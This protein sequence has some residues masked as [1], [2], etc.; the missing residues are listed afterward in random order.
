MKIPT[1]F[2]SSKWTI[3]TDGLAHWVAR[4]HRMTIGNTTCFS[5]LSVVTD[6][7]VKELNKQDKLELAEHG[8]MYGLELREH[9]GPRLSVILAI[10]DV[11]TLLDFCHNDDVRYYATGVYITREYAVATNAL[12]LCKLDIRPEQVTGT[13]ETGAIVPRVFIETML[14]AAP[15]GSESISID[16]YPDDGVVHA[17]IDSIFGESQTIAGPFPPFEA[18]LPGRINITS[19]MTWTTDTDREMT[20]AGKNGVIH[21]SAVGSDQ[22]VRYD[23]NLLKTVLKH[24][25][26]KFCFEALYRP[27]LTQTADGRMIFIIGP[28]RF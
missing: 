8:D 6:R 13:C 26:G 4:N 16:I 23:G 27:A 2:T 17:L 18:A 24:S 20:K 1:K 21:A 5:T 22:D 10:K 25:D 7:A 15:K 14:K 9:A 19:E 3:A 12:T 11:K 28:C